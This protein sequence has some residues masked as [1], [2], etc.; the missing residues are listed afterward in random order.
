MKINT[1]NYPTDKLDQS[2]AHVFKAMFV[3]ASFAE[4]MIENEREV[5]TILENPLTDPHTMREQI[6][7]HINRKAINS[8][9]K[10]FNLL[11]G[12]VASTVEEITS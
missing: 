12:E 8:R 1:S 10:M 2:L 6:S 11:A 7:E 9:D 5:V 3:F 4:S